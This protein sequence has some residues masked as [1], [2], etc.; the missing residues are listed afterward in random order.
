MNAVP[1]STNFHFLSQV[2]MYY[3]GARE[4]IEEIFRKETRVMEDSHTEGKG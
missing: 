3:P 4:K 2:R 1:T